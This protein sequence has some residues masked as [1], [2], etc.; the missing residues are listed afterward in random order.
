MYF[1]IVWFIH[2]STPTVLYLYLYFG[3]E[4]CVVPR[5]QQYKNPFHVFRGSRFHSCTYNQSFYLLLFRDASF[6]AK[7]L[8]RHWDRRAVCAARGLYVA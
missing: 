1:E 3:R 7:P 2:Q 8:L 4:S 6:F 5:F